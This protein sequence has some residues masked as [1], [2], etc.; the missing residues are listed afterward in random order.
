[1][2]E[3]GGR[4]S[5]VVARSLKRRL[6]FDHIWGQM[7]INHDINISTTISS[8]SKHAIQSWYKKMERSYWNLRNVTLKSLFENSY[9]HRIETEDGGRNV[10]FNLP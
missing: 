3:K 9:S 10:N 6:K 1:M 5:I 2:L 4:I 7:V 8:I